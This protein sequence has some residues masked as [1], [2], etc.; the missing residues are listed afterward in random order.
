MHLFLRFDQNASSASEINTG[1][2]NIFDPDTLVDQNASDRY[3]DQLNGAHDRI[4]CQDRHIRT[5]RQKK[6]R[7]D[8]RDPA[9]T[10]IEKKCDKCFS[11]GPNNEIRGIVKCMYRHKDCGYAYETA[12]K[13]TDPI[14]SPV[15]ERKKTGYRCHQHCGG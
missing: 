3:L 4:E 2:R 6:S 14:R 7:W 10:G 15:N 12:R 1:Y 5:V 8:R 13:M 9:E 11:A